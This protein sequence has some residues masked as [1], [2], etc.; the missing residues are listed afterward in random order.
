MLGTVAEVAG[1]T[2]GETRIVKPD[3]IVINGLT[4]SVGDRVTYLRSGRIYDGSVEMIDHHGVN[5][6]HLYVIEDFSMGLFWIRDKCIFPPDDVGEEWI[7][8]TVLCRETPVRISAI[9]CDRSVYCA[10]GY[11]AENHY[12]K[13]PLDTLRKL[14]RPIEGVVIKHGRTRL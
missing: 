11:D 10:E 1:E 2:K 8:K 4:Y 7:G 3:S 5:G 14:D 13:F 9:I 6:S 12:Y